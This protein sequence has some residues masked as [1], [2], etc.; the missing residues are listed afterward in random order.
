MSTPA[1]PGRVQALRAIFEKEV[2]GARAYTEDEVINLVPYVL[3]ADGAVDPDALS[4][5]IAGLLGAFL[6][7]LGLGQSATPEQVG[8]ALGA[9]YEANPI[10]EDLLADFL[11]FAGA[12]G[13]G[14]SAADVSAAKKLLGE[15]GSALPVGA[16]EGPGE[17][18]SPLS[19]FTL[20]VPGE[21]GDA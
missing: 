15:A 3:L 2:D 20:K 6:V 5:E 12:G 7:H 18:A 4:D 9:Y 11:K 8:K 13:E 1:D 14:A 21:D 19:R 16:R 17:K 10:N